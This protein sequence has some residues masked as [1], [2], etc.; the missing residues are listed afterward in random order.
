[1]AIALDTSV[2]YALMDRGDADHVAVSEWVDQESEELVTTPLA[3]AEMD[4]LL[5]RVGGAPAAAALRGD[6]AAGTYSVEWWP[7]AIEE[8]VAVADRH[9]SMG[10]GLV[11]ASLLALAARLGTISVATLDERHF[12]VVKPLT[13]EPAFT[14]LP[15]DR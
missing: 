4:Y 11:D 15:A 2:V 3:V 5:T 10:L 14:L 1:V 9:E 7:S 12:R 6:L 13:G 8:T